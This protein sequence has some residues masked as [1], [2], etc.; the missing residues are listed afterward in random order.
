MRPP[1]LL[2]VVLVALVVGPTVTTPVVAATGPAVDTDVPSATFRGPATVLADLDDAAAVR[3]AREHGRL[4]RSDV[5]V[6]GEVVVFRFQSPELNRSVATARGANTTARFFTVLHETNATASVVQLRPPVE[7]QRFRVALR[8]STV[9]VIRDPETATFWLA[10][11]T[12][13]PTLTTTDGDPLP[14]RELDPGA[15]LQFEVTVTPG[16]PSALYAERVRFVAF[17]LVP[18]ELAGDVTPGVPLYADAN[19][20]LQFG[21]RAPTLPGERVTLRVRAPDG[22]VLNR[23]VVPATPM[24][25]RVATRVDATLSLDG[26]DPG[27]EFTVDAVARNR[28][29]FERRGL[30]G[31]SPTLSNVT[32]VRLPNGTTR[33][34][35]TVR[36]PDDGFLYVQREADDRVDTVPVPGGEQVRVDVL[37]SGLTLRS[38]VYV[39]AWWDVN[40]DAQFAPAGDPQDEPWQVDDSLLDVAVRVQAATPTA[41]RTRRPTET[42]T[43]PVPAPGTTAARTTP[44]GPGGPGFGVVTTLS[45]LAG[46]LVLAWR[47]D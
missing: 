34:G 22:T 46:L 9:Q 29:L 37:V 32:A 23:T 31:D 5:A 28:T 8:E 11:D 2:A 3:R 36:Y 18:T 39:V 35:A 38:E 42:P 25:N 21:G 40:G 1:A 12:T 45:A 10:L 4:R 47:R 15:D 13:D 27:D 17:E 33:I 16:D 19:G 43:A 24:E 26:L 30:V 20:T 41:T 7:R 44:L 6:P 14:D